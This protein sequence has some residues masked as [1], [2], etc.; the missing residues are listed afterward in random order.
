[1]GV[2]QDKPTILTIHNCLIFDW[3]SFLW[4]NSLHESSIF[5]HIL[6]LFVF[7][8]ICPHMYFNIVLMWKTKMEVS[9][10]T[11]TVENTNLW[12][13]LLMTVSTILAAR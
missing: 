2:T 10:L 5:L 8:C 12:N 6:L 9:K 13:N 11:N 1:M 3:N 7:I 4:D